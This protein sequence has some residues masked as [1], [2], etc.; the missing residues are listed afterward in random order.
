[1]WFPSLILVIPSIALGFLLVDPILNHDLLGNAIK[2]LP[3]HLSHETHLNAVQQLISFWHH[4]AVWLA[5]LGILAAF[6]CVIK[7]P[8]IRQWFTQRFSLIYRIL[9]AKYGFDDFNQWVFVSGGKRLA[10]VLFNVVDLRWLDDY[11]VNG[12]GRLITRFS[13]TLKRLQT[14]YLYH[15]AFAMILGVLL[16]LIVLFW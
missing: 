6:L 4:P 12:S 9:V 7:Y 14:G 15:Y 5:A 13:A 8:D 2:V 10:A 3:I 1:M 11:V 16:F